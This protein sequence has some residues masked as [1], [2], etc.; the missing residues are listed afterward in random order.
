MKTY[1]Y[2]LV[3]H[4][5]N[6]YQPTDIYPKTDPKVME[7]WHNVGK[8]IVNHPFGNGLYNLF[9]VICWI[10]YGIVLPTLNRF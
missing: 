2:L 5:S 10:V 9:M 8:T 7:Y 4:V 3:L 1:S 6:T